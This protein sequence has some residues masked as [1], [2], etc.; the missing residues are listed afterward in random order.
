MSAA[1]WGGVAEG[2]VGAVGLAFG[3]GGDFGAYADHG[4]DEAVELG[5]R[6][7]FGGFDHEGAGDGP[8]HGGGVKTVILEAFGDVFDLD[9]GGGGEAAQS[10]MHSWATVFWA[11]A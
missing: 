8:G 11:P 4:V 1:V 7:A 5:Q 3:D 10:R 9:A 2:V 6:F